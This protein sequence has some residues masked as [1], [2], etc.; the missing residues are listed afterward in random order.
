M[1][2]CEFYSYIVEVAEQRFGSRIFGRRE[3]MQAVENQLKASNQWPKKYD[4]PSTSVGK[5]T[6][7]MERIDYAFMPLRKDG[8]LVRLGHDQ[9]RVS[10]GTPDIDQEFLE[11]GK[12]MSTHLKVERDP[13]VIRQKKEAVW[14]TKGAFICEVCEFDF[15]ET[16]STLGKRFIECHH[17]V[18]LSSLQGIQKKTENADLILVCSN[19]HRM[20]HRHLRECPDSYSLD[21][22]KQGLL[23]APGR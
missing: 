22:I 2:N 13:E 6:K 5:K 21:E 20:V 15:H 4:L 18:P 9:Y 10:G 7:G 17:L 1:L 23:C 12:V 14:K 19:C 8:R 11:G 3:L 16:Y